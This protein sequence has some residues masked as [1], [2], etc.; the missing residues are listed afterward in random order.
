MGG[1]KKQDVAAWCEAVCQMTDEQ[2][3]GSFANHC[4]LKTF[5]PK[6]ADI[7]S[8]EG[9]TARDAWTAADTQSDVGFLELPDGSVKVVPGTTV[10]RISGPDNP[11][12]ARKRSPEAQ[13]RWEALMV[14]LEGDGKAKAFR[15]AAQA[16]ETLR[17]ERRKGV[18]NQ[19]AAA[20]VSQ[21]ADVVVSAR[22]QSSVAVPRQPSYDDILESESLLQAQE[23]N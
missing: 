2:I 16:K 1:V 10:P 11:A 13:T 18:R 20:P 3:D 4:R 8:P 9:R 5:W 15:R 17:E 12:G 22:K 19:I 21:L 23:R 14:A 7:V 6:F